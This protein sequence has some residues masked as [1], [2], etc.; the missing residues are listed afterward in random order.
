MA[1]N[2]INSK[3]PL[4]RGEFLPKQKIRLWLSALFHVKQSDRELDSELRFHVEK[5]TEARIRAGLSPQEARQAALREFGSVDLAK[6]ECREERGTQF[7]TEAWQDTR[8]AL[9]ILAKSPGFT[10]V[11]IAALALGIGAN[12]AIFSVV[13]AVLFHPLPYK[14]PARVMWVAN[15]L[16]SQNHTIAFDA[17]YFAWRRASHAFQDMAAFQSFGTATLT[18]TGEPVRLNSATV[19]SSFLNVLGVSPR[20]GRDFA[21]GEDAP[22]GPRVVL[23]TDKLWRERFSTDSSII[24]TAITLDGNLCTIVGVLPANFE[25]FGGAHPDLLLPYKLEDRG[26]A[27]GR[28]ILFVNVIGRLRDGVSPEAAAVDIDTVNGP[29]HAGFPGGYRKMVAGA[30]AIVIP[31]PVRLTSHAKPAML[32]LLG[33]VGFVL[34]IACANVANLQLAR[35]VAREK[36]MAIRGALGAGR[37]R[38]A[39][40]L[41]AESS[42]LG[43]LGGA[44][45]LILAAWIVSLVRHYG[46]Q[47]IAH[48]ESAHLDWHVLLL[49]LALSLVMGL[50]FGSAPVF[51]TFRISVNESLKE[52]GGRGSSAAR[53]RRPQ[54]FLIVAEL[55]LALVLLVGAGLLVRSFVRLI[56]IPPG[57]DPHGVIAATVSLP[58][59]EYKTPE[60]RHAFFEDLVA[61]LQAMPAVTSVGGGVVLPLQGFYSSAAISVEGRPPANTDISSSQGEWS[62]YFNT[63]TPGYFTT[64]RIPL[65]M[66]RNLDSRDVPGAPRS[67][68][69]NQAFVRRFFHNESAV[70]KRVS[71]G[72]DGIWWTIVGVVADARQDLTEEVDPQIFGTDQLDSVSVMEL[73]VRSNGDPA[74]LA[75][76][77]RGQ[78]AAMDK[79]LPIYDVQTLD[80]LLSGITVVR[81]FNTAL[82]GSF[83]GL[84]V[85]LAAV[86]IYGVMSYA[87]GQRTHEIGIRMALGAA[88]GDVLRM[89]LGNG[90]RLALAGVALGLAASFGLTGLIRA[91]LYGVT[92]TDPITFAGVAILLM[93]V[94]LFACWIP[95]R[96]ATRVD[97]ITA[98][99]NE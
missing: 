57:F 71:W 84:A 33:A 83:A 38:L 36:E 92:P 19:T 87:V 22:N 77:I 23:L 66:G 68:V 52:S 10:A 88:R 12:S 98:L 15:Y 49:T 32:I 90:L 91:Q 67:V 37:W 94:A 14:D 41:L 54:R 28:S 11:A 74:L 53:A 20:L 27:V 48:L 43:L 64:L 44:A 96:R 2:K 95:A 62:S 40:Q 85:L 31:L 39:R 7:I 26:I 29:L 99:R 4:S 70:G 30:R 9:R 5:Q 1:S 93:A 13:N 17:D 58:I 80:D 82:I 63:V 69:V 18:R 59:N 76:A 51:S 56:S 79:D 8:F 78:V 60:Q 46:P 55:A 21:V 75:P 45:G 50:L 89:V 72:T 16:P 24:G 81:R 34:L 86:G 42:L 73:V 47:D 35:A 6:E 65:L 25:F 97:P 3:S 61:R